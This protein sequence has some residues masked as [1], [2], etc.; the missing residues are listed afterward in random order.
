VVCANNR[1]EYV[2]KDLIGWCHNKDI[3]LQTTA[4]HTPEQNGVAKQ[5]NWTILELSHTMLIS[6]DMPFEL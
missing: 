5:W 3:E 1:C 6:R 4:S 2:N